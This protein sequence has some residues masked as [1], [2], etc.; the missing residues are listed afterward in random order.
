MSQKIVSAHLL[1]FQKL[2]QKI[3]KYKQIHV[4]RNMENIKQNH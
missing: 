2:T 4:P 1:I 3:L